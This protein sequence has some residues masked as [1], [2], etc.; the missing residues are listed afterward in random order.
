MSDIGKSIEKQSAPYTQQARKPMSFKEV[1]LNSMQRK[2]NKDHQCCLC[3]FF[4]DD[5]SNFR[6]SNKGHYVCAECACDWEVDKVCPVCKRSSVTGSWKKE[7]S[8]GGLMG[9][10][11]KMGL[12]KG[13]V[14]GSKGGVFDR[15]DS[16]EEE[17]EKSNSII[18]EKK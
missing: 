10:G 18:G 11:E 16:C 1:Y 5:C 3:L 6:C 17:E 9:K 14:F 15:G 13:S 4:S 8:L 7:R 12:G 2:K